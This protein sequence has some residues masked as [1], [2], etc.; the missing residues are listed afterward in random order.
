MI[1]ITKKNKIPYFKLIIWYWYTW[2]SCEFII[3]EFDSSEFTY[4]QVKQIEKEI[5]K[6][7]D[8]RFK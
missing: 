6:E 4:K 7:M 3:H 2:Y 5:K 1:L 8:K